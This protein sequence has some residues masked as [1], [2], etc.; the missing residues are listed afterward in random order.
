MSSRKVEW[1][2]ICG[3]EREGRGCRIGFAVD[4]VDVSSLVLE[5]DDMMAMDL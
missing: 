1:D 4:D 3:D 2:C 5:D